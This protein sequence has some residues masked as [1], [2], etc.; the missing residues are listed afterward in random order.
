MRG[1]IN[2][3]TK[4]HEICPSLHTDM[5]QTAVGSTN[6]LPRS[7]IVCLIVPYR[8]HHTRKM[9]H[10]FKKKLFLLLTGFVILFSIIQNCSSQT[11]NRYRIYQRYNTE[12][13][14]T[15]QDIEYEDEPEEDP[16]KR[17][18]PQGNLSEESIIPHGYD[19]LQSPNQND[20][21]IRVEVSLIIFN[22]RDINEQNQ[23]FNLEINFRMYWEDKRLNNTVPPEGSNF[24]VL[25][26]KLLP[27]IWTPDITIDNVKSL[28]QP[29]LVSNPS[30]L[31]IYRG[32]IVRYSARLTVKM[33]CNMDFQYYP[34]DT[35]RCKIC[36]RSFDFNVKNLELT[37]HTETEAVRIAKDFV[38]LSSYDVKVAGIDNYPEAVGRKRAL[39]WVVTFDMLFKRNLN[40]HMLQ[41]FFP[42]I[43]FVVISWLSFLVPVATVSARMTLCMSTLLTL[44]T[45][46]AVVRQNTPNESYA[47]ALDVWMLACMFFVFITLVEYAFLLKLNSIKVK[48]KKNDDYDEEES[49][50]GFGNWRKFNWRS[51]NFDI[52]KK[53]KPPE[54]D[55]PSVT[56]ISYLS[57][58]YID[59]KEFIPYQIRRPKLRDSSR[60]SSPM[61]NSNGSQTGYCSSSSSA[62]VPSF[63]PASITPQSEKP[64]GSI[65]VR[66]IDPD[67][68]KK[69]AVSIERVAT[70]AI[71]SLFVF[72]NLIF[73][74]TLLVGSGYFVDPVL[75]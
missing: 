74:P 7:P 1:L 6:R 15:P 16:E 23:D 35:Q 2:S 41:T 27:K 12:I 25:N 73:W 42:S 29:V 47:K 70:V 28:S 22:I 26:P 38:V 44:T 69:I 48:M 9:E 30:S 31:R 3:V 58:Y 62:S 39:S 5:L 10:N 64:P 56:P 33:A 36:L 24:V 45:M 72:F 37:W 52:L 59:G 63:T 34:A 40:Y 65:N 68:Y 18:A 8:L 75:K 54:E 60:E 4:V 32:S 20:E 67:K 49:S 21:A 13:P 66:N 50:H 53:K 19:A 71:P 43:I 61:T 55:S 57:W 51:L 17:S 46:F 14:T 11:T